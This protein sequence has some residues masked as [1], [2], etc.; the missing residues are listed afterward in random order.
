MKRIVLAIAFLLC[1]VRLDATPI[2]MLWQVIPGDPFGGGSGG[3]ISFPI[4][5]PDGSATAPSYSFANKPSSGMY[6]SSSGAGGVF[7]RGG[8]GSGVDQ[9]GGFAVLDGGRG[10]GLGDGGGVFLRVAT[11]G[12]ASGSSLN[13]IQDALTIQGANGAMT[14]GSID[15]TGTPGNMS[16]YA[17]RRRTGVTDGAGG[18]NFNIFGSQ[19]TGTGIGGNI[20]LDVA[21]PG[22]TG[23]AQNNLQEVILLSGTTGDVVITGALPNG[24]ARGAISI[25]GGASASGSNLKFDRTITGAGN[26]G[27]QTINKMAGCVNFA[28]AATTL[29]VT[30]SIATATSIILANAMTNDTTCHVKDVE[31][32]SGSF[33]IRMTAA[34]TAETAVCF[35]LSN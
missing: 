19:G 2:L 32:A 30:D 23:S 17:A 22:A 21:P 3:G 27:A 7:V 20:S 9:T 33:T 5:A 24:A 1:A 26:T 15:V 11:P 31:R 35:L 28:A 8:N 16:L 25:G 6:A 18:E 29:V 10:T 14:F 12:T 4:L 13:N 34:C